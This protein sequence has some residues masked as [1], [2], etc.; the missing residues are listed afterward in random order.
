MWVRVR[1]VLRLLT[2]NGFARIGDPPAQWVEMSDRHLTENC[3]DKN[4][5][6]IKAAGVDCTQAMQM[7]GG[8]EL[9]CAYLKSVAA[10][11]FCAQV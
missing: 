6:L 2:P 8:L 7:L 11:G 9:G 5:D 4:E 10:L 1:T 3:A